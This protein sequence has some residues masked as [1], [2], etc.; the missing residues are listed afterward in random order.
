MALT[1]W[2]DVTIAT[3]LLA[4]LLLAVNS[5]VVTCH[6]IPYTLED[7][8]RCAQAVLQQ[9]KG[10]LLCSS[11]RP[12]EAMS[13][14]LDDGAVLLDQYAPRGLD[15]VVDDGKRFGEGSSVVDMTVRATAAQPPQHCAVARL[16][17]D[18]VLACVL[19]VDLSQLPDH[20]SH[21]K[22]PSARHSWRLAVRDCCCLRLDLARHSR[23]R[24]CVT[25]C[26]TCSSVLMRR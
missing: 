26:E 15:Y 11:I 13:G 21:R 24:Q 6:Y 23:P 12:L 22:A 17:L 18:S 20:A 9:M 3:G 7:L 2:L 25:R 14:A 5:L 10:P 1:T 4:V 8:P 16:Q 19:A